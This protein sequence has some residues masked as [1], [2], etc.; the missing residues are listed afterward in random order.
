MVTVGVVLLGVAALGY[1]YAWLRAYMALAGTSER[2]LLIV[3]VWC[4]T[5]SF[6]RGPDVLAK[7]CRLGQM[8]TLLALTATGLVFAAG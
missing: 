7:A 4:F 3:P 8:F 2:V 6:I 1:M 5:P